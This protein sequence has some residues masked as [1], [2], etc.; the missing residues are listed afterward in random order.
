MS[1]GKFDKAFRSLRR[2]RGSDIRAAK[3]LY[4]IHAQMVQEH[5]LIEQSAVATNANVFTR[6]IELFKI[7]RLRRAVQASGIVMI[8]QQ[9]CGSMQDPSAVNDIMLTQ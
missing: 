9:M 1:K 2:L 8:A 6:F 4:Y 7:P 3:E 5:I